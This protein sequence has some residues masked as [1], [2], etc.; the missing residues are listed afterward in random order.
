M[1]FFS[2]VSS[3]AGNLTGGFIGESDAEKAAKEGKKLSG[4]STDQI[5]AEFADTIGLV[6]EDLQPFIDTG[7]LASAEAFKGIH[8][9]P[10][11]PFN[12][13]AS[14]LGQTDAFK[15]RQQQG[16]QQL[17]RTASA[18]RGLTSGNRL[19]GAQQFGQGLASTEFENEFTRQLLGNQV[20]NQINEGNTNRLLGFAINGQ[21][22]AGDLGAFRLNTTGSRA[23][24]L[25]GNAANQF[26]ASLI[27]AQEK[28]NFTNSAA[29]LAGQLIKPFK[30]F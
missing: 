13:D 28:A 15:F 8:D 1:G 24:A 2:G 3:L 22:A 11:Q 19:V 30:V 7:I 14:Q 17:D 23:N 4:R 20:N 5:L 26:A 18:N 16:Q 10:L 27:P 6:A 29:G 21:R 25:T 9:N 12:F